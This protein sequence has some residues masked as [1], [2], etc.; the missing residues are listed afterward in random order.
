MREGLLMLVRLQ[1]DMQLAGAA[2]S[3][4]E[5]VQLHLDLQP[6]VTVFDLDFPAGDPLAAVRKIRALQPG[7]CLIGL[8]TY[9][10]ENRLAGAIDAGVT[11][12]AVRDELGDTLPALIRSAA[13]SMARRP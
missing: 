5:G 9:R 11:H 4:E 2:V 3:V 1:P 8:S 10:Q 12:C 13:R 7:A 6:D